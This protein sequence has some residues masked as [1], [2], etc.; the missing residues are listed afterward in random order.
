MV[1]SKEEKQIFCTQM[2][3]SVYPCYITVFGNLWM[4]AILVGRIHIDIPSPFIPLF[5]FVKIKVFKCVVYVIPLVTQRPVSA[6]TTS[7]LGFGLCIPKLYFENGGC[8]SPWEC[9]G[10]N[11]YNCAPTA[12][13]NY[14][15]LYGACLQSA[16]YILKNDVWC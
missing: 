16:M 3:Q 5:L 15:C 13:P 10:L 14:C 9:Y 7:E 2:Y 8:W 1:N 4:C 11:C 6:G 12:L